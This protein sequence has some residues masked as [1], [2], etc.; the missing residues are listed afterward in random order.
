[1]DNGLWGWWL[2]NISRWIKINGGWKTRARVDR[3]ITD[4]FFRK[5]GR[6]RNDLIWRMKNMTHFLSLFIFCV[7]NFRF[8]WLL[9]CDIYVEKINKVGG[10]QK[11]DFHF[12]DTLY[13]AIWL[14]LRTM[15]SD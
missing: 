4:N 13:Y 2:I 9:I 6:P 10:V 11:S 3:G 1:M 14:R 12:S 15:L 8:I 5:M 7:S